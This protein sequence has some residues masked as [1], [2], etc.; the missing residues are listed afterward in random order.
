LIIS[1]EGTLT[2]SPLVAII[3]D[4]IIKQGPIPFI[5]FME[6]A[7]YHPEFGYYCSPHDK[8]GLTAD[9]DT[10]PSVHPVFAKLL[11]KQILQMILALGNKEISLI[12]FGA[13]EGTLCEGI[14]DFLQKSAPDIFRRVTYIIIETS[15]SFQ[16][17]QKE[18]LI[19]VYANTVLWKDKMPKGPIGIVLSN[20]FVDALPVHRMRKNKELYVNWENG[21]FTER[22][23]SPS[24]PAL[25]SYLHQVDIKPDEVFDYE[26]NLAGLDWIR[27]VGKSLKKGFVMTIDYGYP[28]HQLYHP[29]R[30]RGTLLCY[31]KH[32]V[33]EDPY[34]H[35]GEQDM[36]SHVDFTSLAKVGEE[37]G[38]NVLGFTDQ[39]HFLMGLGIT[40]EMQIVA[41]NM[42]ESDE[43]KRNFLAMKELMAPNKMG[44]TFKILIQ[45]K[46][47]VPCEG[48]TSPIALDG[49]AFRAF[50]KD[51]LMRYNIPVGVET[52]QPK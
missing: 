35:I 45:E 26:I 23:D 16:A 25:L 32:T 29:S 40:H 6:L 14:L 8:I 4:E 17:R 18:R 49:L 11:G 46:G 28:A 48:I 52:F 44:K 21:K 13:G 30:N 7:L 36:T 12:E 24:S 1:G 22:F 9:Y 19:P 27:E 39:T 51:A 47:T 37:V 42:E 50:A 20:E 33:C 5:R 34:A 3:R 43:A 41:E 2:P 10:S 38:L 31:Y 15:S